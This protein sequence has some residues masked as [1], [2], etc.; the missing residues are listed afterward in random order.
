MTDENDLQP[1]TLAA[2]ALH[3]VDPASGG[4]VPPIQPASTFA[5]TSHIW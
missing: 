5:R 3:A 2:Q 1:E 4:I